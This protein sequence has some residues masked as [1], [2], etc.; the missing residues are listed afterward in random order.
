MIL[1]ISGSQSSVSRFINMVRLALDTSVTCAP[2]LG[3]PV[4]FQMTQVSILPKSTSPFSALARTPG[5]I[6][7]DPLD[8]RAG[9]VGGQRQTDFGAEAI[10]AAVLG[11]IVADRV[12]A[13]VLPDDGIVDRLARG[14]L[15]HDGGLALI[16]DADGREILELQIVLGQRAVDHILAALP[17]FHR[18]VLDPARL[19]VNLLVFFLIDAHH[20]ALM[21]EDHEAGAGRALIDCAYIL[22]H[23]NPS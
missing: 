13:G 16:G 6:V 9:E 17:D 18:I 22:S 11:Q 4:R 12:R 21:I 14:L 5:D 1:S 8:L 15:P 7:E 2:P 3:P 20:L 10:L 19:G 23:S